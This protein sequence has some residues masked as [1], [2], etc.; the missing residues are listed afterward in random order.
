MDGPSSAEQSYLARPF[1]R[2]TRLILAFPRTT[3][4]IAIVLAVLASVYSAARLGYRANRLDLVNPNSETTRFW[5]RY[6][7][8][9]GSEDDAV[10]VVEGTSRDQ[11][12]PVID[13]LAAAVARNDR[14]L[15]SVLHRVDLVKLRSKGLYYLPA[16][17]LHAIDG[18]LQEVV[19]IAAGQWS[20]L[21]VGSLAAGMLDR[22]QASLT[23]RA[24][25]GPHGANHAGAKAVDP[26]EGLAALT[27]FCDSLAG[28]LQRQP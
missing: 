25:R 4:W 18:Y 1:V 6:A 26:A 9:F 10:I 28:A 24:A 14:L 27:T 19:P 2:G 23:Q 12:I 17:Q 13:E 22:M 15:H 7:E 3:L 5:N 11:I 16:D 21:N 20:R 8:E